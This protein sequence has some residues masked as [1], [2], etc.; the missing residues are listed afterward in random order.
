MINEE[1]ETKL[2]KP[3][4]HEETASTLEPRDKRN[5][6]FFIGKKPLAS[7]DGGRE[8]R[9]RLHRREQLTASYDASSPTA[10]ARTRSPA[11][12]PATVDADPLARTTMGARRSHRWT[13]S[14]PA[15]GRDGIGLVTADGPPRSSRLPLP[16]GRTRRGAGRSP[17]VALAVARLRRP[18]S[19][20]R[21]SLIAAQ[22]TGRVTP[23]QPCRT[24]L[25]PA[26]LTRRARSLVS[27]LL[28]RRGDALA[29]SSPRLL[30]MVLAPPW[31]RKRMGANIYC[32]DLNEYVLHWVA[33]LSNR[34]LSLCTMRAGGERGDRAR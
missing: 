3:F 7:I 27:W 34:V 8:L 19:P 2:K 12:P 23:Q 26:A 17:S 1:R 21:R 20:R 33:I 5:S 22:V 25:P 10:A 14:E 11:P 30:A 6:N 15:R 9:T 4:S 24:C 18:R 31:C 29:H 28:A 13:S 32:I 16:G